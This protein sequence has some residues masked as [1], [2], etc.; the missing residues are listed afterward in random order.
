MLK[1][2]RSAGILL[3]I[4]SLPSKHGIGTLGKECFNFIDFLSAAGLKVWQL[5]P[6]NVTSY[7]DSP[8]QSPSSVGLNYYF[9]DL[10]ILLNKG[11]L[12][13]DDISQYEFSNN[14]HRI[15]YGLLFNN[16]L[17]LLKKAFKR[18]DVS[19]SKFIEFERKGLYHDFAFYMTLKTLHGFS[20]WY[21]WNDETKIYSPQ[22]EEKIIHDNL[23]LYLFFIW[24]QFEF[25]NQFFA[26]KKYANQHGISL[27]GDIPLY[28]SYDSVEAYKCPELFLFDHNH[29]PTSVAGCPPDAFTEDGQLW[30]NPL[31]NWQKME[32]NGFE[33]F[34]ERIKYNLELFDILRID[35][36]R[37]FSAYYS[38]PFGMKNARVG[39]WNKG[40]GM[41]L[42]KGK[43]DLPIIAEDLGV[44]DDDVLQLIKDTGYPGMKILEFAFDGNKD[45]IHLP[46]NVSENN[47]IYTG[48]HDN[49]PLY[50]YLSELNEKEYTVFCESLRKQCVLFDV[51]YA[52]KTL[53]DVVHTVIKL[54]FASKAFLSVIPYQDVLSLGAET[55]LNFPSTLGTSNWSYRFVAE[56]FDQDTVHFLHDLVLK[57]KR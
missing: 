10:D 4:F 32:E 41:K 43:E 16:R 6:L 47:V 5:L 17:K 52:D 22:L 18:F 20:P 37:G 8:Y 51:E 31:Y 7:G 14:P 48:T 38:I 42:F 54:C 25:I 33:F 21:E 45:N 53:S 12:T 56:Q 34:N 13:E 11:L 50:G 26:V 40:P 39:F 24:T 19:N 15:D 35:N 55:R 23:E 9:I 29:R 27:V 44:L 46:S 3:P 1:K 30:G 57:Y 28:L 49:M 2:S 36:F